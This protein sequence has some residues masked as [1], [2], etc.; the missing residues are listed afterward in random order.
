MQC[1]VVAAIFVFFFNAV[2]YL[3]AELRV[4]SDIAV[5]KQLMQIC[6]QQYPVTEIMLL[7]FGKRHDVRRFECRKRALTRDGATAI[8]RV[9][10]LRS[11]SALPQ[12]RNDQNRLSS[13]VSWGVCKSKGRRRRQTLENT[14]PIAC[15]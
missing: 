7:D 11:K 1:V 2:A 12:A 13:L 4:D 14:L 8:V 10:Y 5:V 9:D 6:S 15:V 3:E